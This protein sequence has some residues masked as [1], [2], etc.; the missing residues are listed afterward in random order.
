[1]TLALPYGRAA[2]TPEKFSEQVDRIEPWY[3]HASAFPPGARSSKRL[4]E[5]SR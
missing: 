5:V 4:S 3:D 1:M 2:A